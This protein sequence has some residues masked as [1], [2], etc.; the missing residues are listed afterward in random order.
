MRIANRDFRMDGSRIYIMGILNLTPDSFSDGGL[1]TNRDAALH[2]V[3]EMLRDGADVIDLGAESTR[4]GAEEV[5]AEEEME[6]LLPMIE[7][8]K[9]GFDVP[10]SVDSYK[11]EVMDAA[12]EAGADLANDIWGFR[13]ETLHPELATGQKETMAEV[14]ARHGKPAVLMHN[15]L[16]ARNMAERTEEQYQRSGV[17]EAGRNDVITRVK[18][19]WEESLRIAD[20]AGVPRDRI[21]LDPGVGFAKTQEENLRC[22]GC[23]E[24]FRGTGSGLLLGTSR[25]SVLG[26]LLDIPTGERDEATAATSLLGAQ[27]GFSFV[28]VHEIKMNRRMLDFW[29]KLREAVPGTQ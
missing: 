23:L 26:N 7:C 10:V 27:A 9:S 25:K 24:Q 4:P 22:I 12:F 16:L 15:D 3:E 5:T 20:E 13:Y 11:A 18:E 29:E 14:V 8:I 6:R 17:S 19:G 2:H 21:L 1:F 28:R